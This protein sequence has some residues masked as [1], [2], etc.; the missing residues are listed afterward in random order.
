MVPF[1]NHD[2]GDEGFVGAIPQ[3]GAGCPDGEKL[4]GHYGLEL[5]LAHSV[6][7]HD[8]PLGL[9]LGGAVE[10][11]QKLPDDVLHVLDHLLVLVS[12]LDPDLDLVFHLGGRVHGAH[13]GGDTRL[14]PLELGRGVR[15]VSSE[16]HQRLTEHA[17]PRVLLQHVI[18]SRQLRVD[19]K[20]QIGND[21]VI[22]FT[23]KMKFA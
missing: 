22:G 7:E 9:L 18:C 17:G 11:Q 1:L 15:H 3:L 20:A 21:L 8:Q 23:V 10:L 16:Y 13:H 19:L 14:D 2:V 6:P 12:L 4:P 5:A